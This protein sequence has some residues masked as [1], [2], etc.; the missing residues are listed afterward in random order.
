LSLVFA[1]TFCGWLGAQSS[2]K[3][4]KEEP[5]KS[6]PKGDRKEELDDGPARPRKVINV[7]DDD[8]APAKPKRKPLVPVQAEGQTSLVEAL[9]ETK[10]PTLQAL[11]GELK[12]PHDALTVRTIRDQARTVA[13]EPEPTYYP[14]EEPS[15]KNGYIDV[16]TYDAEW[17]RSTSSTKHR[18]ALRLQPYE[19][20]VLDRVDAL[21][22]SDPVRVKLTPAEMFRAAE[23]ALAAADRFHV[24]ARQT[25]ARRG[26]EWEPVGKRLHERL[27]E[28][29]QKRLGTFIAAGD[30]D[31][32]CAYAR[33]LAAAYREQDERTPLAAA[34]VR[35]IQEELPTGA[36]EEQLRRARERF[37]QL[38]DI[39]PGS[40][41]IQAVNRGLRDQ[42]AALLK[43]AE[44]M[45]KAGDHQNAR[46]RLQLARDL[47]PTLPDLAEALARMEEN[48]P[49]LRVGVHDLPLNLIPGQAVT[50]A[51]FRAMELVYEGL[52]KLYVEPGVGQRYVPALAGAVPR[53]V[54]LGREFR[55]AR[56]AAWSDG[57]PVTVGDVKETL[58]AMRSDTWV[59]HSTAWNKLIE[60][61]V[62]GGDSFRLSLHL[63]QGYLDPLSLMSFKVLP[64]MLARQPGRLDASPVGSGPFKYSKRGTYLDRRTVQFLANPAYASREGKLGL[65]RIREI[66]FVQLAPA[67]DPALLLAE[68]KLDMVLDLSA[69][70]AGDK[71]L[72]NGANAVVRG[73]IPSRRVYFLAVNHRA[74]AVRENV[75]LRRA[76]AL[77]ID[78]KKILA[79]CFPDPAGTKAHHSLNGLFPA[80]SWP[81]DKNVPQEL[82]DAEGARAQTAEAVKVNG[83]AIRLELKYPDGDAATAAAVQLLCSSVNELLRKDDKTFIELRPKAVL[84]QNL[85][86]DVE[87]RHDYQLAYYHYDHASETFWVAPLFDIDPQATD[88]RGSNYLGYIDGDLQAQFQRARNHR[89]FSEVQKAMHMIHQT[90][91]LTMPLIPLWQ[92]DTFLAHRKGMNLDRLPVDPLVIFNDVENWEL[93]RR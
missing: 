30:W 12:V 6:R 19:E 21:L 3:E 29:Q 62:G 56:G 2:K 41:A 20:V 77:A 32:A 28:V 92:L 17:R 33:T 15:F 49:V 71:N 23:T 78:R 67:D 86:E 57:T 24:S 79:A 34:L 85:R 72:R 44:T 13:I 82:F 22:K 69:Q 39:F 35:M 42:A 76:L 10:N 45:D 50:D 61:P 60:D 48:H 55:I 89:D 73:P 16:W 40:Q 91:V 37:Q 47:C 51:D 80:E 63:S 4:D 26:S 83:E 7:D 8:P 18:S 31:G 64:S 43:Q 53:L 88:S 5:A 84:P 1:V 36:P 90:L 70:Q 81:C 65:P 9:R 59:G 25:G 52:V 46:L 54:P 87:V 11:F 68:G 14:D 93:G 74:P 66:H 27:F 58:R 38:E 75:A